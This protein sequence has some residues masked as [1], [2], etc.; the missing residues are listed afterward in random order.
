MGRD[1]DKDASRDVGSSSKNATLLVTDGLL[2]PL[3]V[4]TFFIPIFHQLV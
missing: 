2:K 1:G 4:G 3:L